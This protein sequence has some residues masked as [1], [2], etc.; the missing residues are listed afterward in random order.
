M[1]EVDPLK[2]WLI[3]SCIGALGFAARWGDRGVITA[4]AVGACAAILLYVGML[5]SIAVEGTWERDSMAVGM[6]LMLVPL[7]IMAWVIGT[8]PGA[9]LGLGV[10]VLARRLST[11]MDPTRRR[12]AL[13]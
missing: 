9:L 1:T 4:W 7:Y 11:N 10:N 5:L 12:R 3:A 8:L 2:I 13:T 6:G